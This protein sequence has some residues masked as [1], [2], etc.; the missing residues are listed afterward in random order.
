[1]FLKKHWYQ[2]G[3]TSFQI[4]MTIIKW[5]ASVR[6]IL[7]EIPRRSFPSSGRGFAFKVLLRTVML[8]FSWRDTPSPTFF[9]EQPYLKYM[10]RCSNFQATL[11]F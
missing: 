8:P 10:V 11:E 3:M 2:A 6:S 1:M 4:R 7:G 9:S 5:V